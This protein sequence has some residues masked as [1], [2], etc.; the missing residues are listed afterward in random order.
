MYSSNFPS[1]TKQPL[2]QQAMA[3]DMKLATL[4]IRKS[5]RSKGFTLVE[6]LVVMAIIATLLGLGVGAIKNMA[7]SKGVSSAVPLADSIFAQARQV[8]KSSGVPTRVVIY[9]DYGGS[10]EDKRSRY[11]R[12]VGVATGR[13]AGEPASKGQT[14]E[15]WRL[16]S[17]PIILPSN[18]FFNAK[19]SNKSATD[20]TAIFPGDIAPKNCYVYEFNSEGALIEASNDGSGAPVDNGQFV[21]QAGKLRPGQDIPVVDRNATR[22]LGGFKIWANGRMAMFRS[23]KQ[24]IEASEDP[25]F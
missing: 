5:I 14:I 20:G 4:P 10:D 3:T 9:A 1:S 12:T 11:L 24:I 8:A 2:I 7:S 16:V 25:E 17:R 18:T 19:L 13:V 22:D 15:E 23:P 6:I 21:V